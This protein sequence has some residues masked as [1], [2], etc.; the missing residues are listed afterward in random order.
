M[1]TAALVRR[2]GWSN[3]A[4]GASMIVLVVVD[5]LLGAGLGLFFP[6]FA[7]V[8]AT[9]AA[10]GLA[11]W[12]ELAHDAPISSTI[13]AMVSAGVGVQ[14]GYLGGALCRVLNSAVGAAN[15][16]K[17]PQSRWSDPSTRNTETQLRSST[18]A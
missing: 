13:L 11:A 8:P 18:G 2:E 9:A 6:V 1:L 10:I 15:W 12:H 17:S 7:L 3:I 4:L 16:I 14:F 5:V